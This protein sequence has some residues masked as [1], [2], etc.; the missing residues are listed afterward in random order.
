MNRVRLAFLALLLSF[1]APA[2]LRATDPPHDTATYGGKSGCLAC[3]LTHRAPGGT[4]TSVSGNSNLCLTCH[5]T[6]G[7]A[8]NKPLF[9]SNEALPT[10]GL[11]TGMSAAG[12]THRWDSGPQ[13][14][15]TRIGGATPASTGKITPSGVYTGVFPTTIEIKITSAGNAGTAQF[16]WRSTSVAGVWG[17]ASASFTTQSLPFPLT[18][19]GVSVAF[20]N[21][22]G[23]SFQAGDVW[24][25]YLRT[26][27]RAPTTPAMAIRLD[28]NGALMC[29]TCHDQHLQA[30]APYDPSSSP[31][32]T[33]GVTNNRRFQRVANDTNGMCADCHA[34]RNVVSGGGSHPV[35]VAVS[36][37]NLQAPTAPLAVR[38]DNKVQCLTCHQLHDSATND[39]S[40][41]RVSYQTGGG[42]PLCTNCHLLADTS[43]TPGAHFN[44]TATGA[45]W[46]GDGYGGSAYPAITDTTQRGACKNCHA[47]HGWPDAASP[48]SNY[49]KLLGARQDNLCTSCHDSNGPSNKDVLTQISKTGSRHPVDRTSG[50]MVGCAD[51][52]NPHMAKVGIHTAGGTNGNRIR[53]AAGTTIYSGALRGVDGLLFNYSGLGNWASPPSQTGASNT[54]F[55]KIASGSP[56]TPATG[57]EYEYQVCFK[58]HT[59]Y[60]F[61]STPPSSGGGTTVGAFTLA[62]STAQQTWT[63]G[64]GTARF[65]QNS[66]VVSGTGTTT[67]AAAWMGRGFRRSSS[68]TNVYTVST[69]VTPTATSLTLS[70][71]FSQTATTTYVAYQ[72]RP[73]AAITTSS[74][75]TG[76]GTNWATTVPGQYI[77]LVGSGTSYEIL[78]RPS[79]TSLTIAPATVS[80]TPADFILHPGAKFTNGSATVTGYGSTGWTSAMAGQAIRPEDG[81]N[82][83]Y[84]VASTP[85][86][87]ATS[88]T[89]TTP[90]AGTTR[91]YRFSTATVTTTPVNSY[92]DVAQEFNPANGSFHPVV[93]GLNS[94]TGN[95]TTNK[96]LTAGQ[97]K[98]PWATNLG[99]QT[100]M[101][102]DCHNTDAATPA[103]QGPHGS[104][105]PFMLAG[106]NKLWPPASGNISSTL[107]NTT[108]CANCHTYN[109]TTNMAHGEHEGRTVTCYNC[110]IL[111]PHGGKLARL[112]GD[113]NSATF[114]ARYAYQGNKANMFV[115]G[116]TKNAP[117][118]YSKSNCGAT[119]ASG[120]HALTNGAQ[121]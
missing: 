66:A 39:G 4:L 36:G 34:A 40:L 93:V 11:P 120:E 83:Y 12:N 48:T 55:T 58:C 107:Y 70:S 108:F 81:S 37:T 18:G 101:C 91:S 13:G 6:N 114:P 28:S 27:L 52:H 14:H 41:L 121:W 63:T 88:L 54:W 26:D 61:G 69:T 43:A 113:G 29:S 62:A 33:E 97:M 49:S 86:P 106:T 38:A 21:G 103:A 9:E 51:C 64:G 99:T 2:L 5:T 85:A 42:N 46:P 74:T 95:G 65:T 96:A 112:I 31:S 44:T 35:G 78:T 110:H 56:A 105:T 118:N 25:L 98:S 19:T 109:G 89:L 68:P 16:Q 45:L 50:R 79:T 116:F 7:N 10:W 87:T 20:T 102:S 90:Y 22:A 82:T 24:H 115:T 71:S 104:A 59:S 60:S 76:Y 67:W 1:S 8:Q 119:C 72:W 17:G 47:P 84:I 73:S 57:A 80:A 94:G 117:G 100:M 75:V 53:N 30:N 32:Y 77:E 92:T 23:T 15:I 3:H 111:V